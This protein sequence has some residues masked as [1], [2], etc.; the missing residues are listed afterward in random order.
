MVGLAEW[1]VF[2]GWPHVDLGHFAGLHREEE[3]SAEFGLRIV[4]F[5]GIPK[6]SPA[7]AMATKGLSQLTKFG[8]HLHDELMR[9]SAGTLNEHVFPVVY[10]R[11]LRFGVLV[12]DQLQHR[13]RWWPCEKIN[14][15]VNL[16]GFIEVEA[17]FGEVL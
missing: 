10:K 7:F 17:S 11:Q 14:V 6:Y 4:G 3:R 13:I 12:P 15:E 16:N 9:Q 2:E 8:L 1:T 5:D